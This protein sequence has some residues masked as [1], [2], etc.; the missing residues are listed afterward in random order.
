M[1]FGDGTQSRAFSVDFNPAQ[2]VTWTLDR[3]S[4]ALSSQLPA[5]VGTEL[6]ELGFASNVA[7]FG[8]D[9][10]TVSDSVTVTAGAAPSPV[11]SGGPTEIG[12]NARV[13]DLWSGGNVTLRSNST[14]TGNV[15]TGG[16]A[17]RQLGSIVSGS[18]FEHAFVPQPSIAWSPSF[19]ATNRGAVV[20][21]PDSARTIVPGAYAQV[22]VA[23]RYTLTLASG[24]YYFDSLVL[25]P[26]SRVVLQG[27][28]VIYVRSALTDRGTFS[29]ASGAFPELLIG[30]FGGTAASIEAPFSGTLLAPNAL[31]RLANV[32]G[33]AYRG[34]FFGKQVE[35]QTSVTVEFVAP[36]VFDHLD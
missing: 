19:P 14:V 12:A 5:C 8:A 25:E 24:I 26:S 35:L 22:S 34:V 17:G 31:L 28:V 10:V 21:N 32:P 36:A 6:T 23:S 18:T 27:Q 20:L 29:D 16:T 33:F 7:V 13:G 15:T 30:Y 11:V 3:T 2:P 4:I 1:E 9:R